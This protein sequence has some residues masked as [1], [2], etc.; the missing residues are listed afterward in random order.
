MKVQV[1]G[2][3][4][5]QLFGLAAGLA[6]A[7]TSNQG[8]IVDL[9]QVDKGVTAHGVSLT[10][11]SFDV[12]IPFAYEAE[13]H[14]VETPLR[15]IAF[16]LSEIAQAKALSPLAKRVPWW[17]TS[18][19]PVFDRAV[20]E[21]FGAQVSHLRGY[22]HSNFFFE[23]C[24]NNSL[25]ANLTVPQ[26]S[27]EFRVTKAGLVGREFTAIHIRRGDYYKPEVG[28]E[29]IPKEW[30]LE[31]L[32]KIERLGDEILIFS[33][34]PKH[35]D[36]VHVASASGGRIVSSKS[37]SPAEELIL[38]SLG[39]NFICSNS[40]F[41]WWAAALSDKSGQVFFPRSWTGY[42]GNDKWIGFPRE[43]QS[44]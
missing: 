28:M 7:H 37:L 32:N 27:E 5:N 8:L 4:G 11:L 6:F 36:V 35:E 30:F 14:P 9:S 1:V 42:P 2:G 20:F 31:S 29:I 21:E 17:Y 16:R 24:A 26:C 23:Y 41:S 13:A 38:M 18:R 34:D 40:T 33:D 10:D 3:L 15:K 12:S 25:L 43:F 44:F 22:F 19:S 39:S